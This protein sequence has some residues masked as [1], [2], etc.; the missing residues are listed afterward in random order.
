M[1]DI[2]ARIGSRAKAGQVIGNFNTLQMLR[3]RESATAELLTNQLPKVNV[4]TRTLVSGATDTAD[5]DA[6]TDFTSSSQDRVT[7]TAVPLIEPAH[8]IALP[9]GQMFSFQEGG[10]LWKVRMPLPKPAS[11]DAMPADLQTLAARMRESYNVN[12]GSWWSSAGGAPTIDF[13]PGM[14]P[15]GRRHTP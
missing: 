10:Q 4:Q 5:P 1:S 13:D 2:E 6:R 7:T 11:D 12:A 9:K 15:P 3:V 8:I 14:P